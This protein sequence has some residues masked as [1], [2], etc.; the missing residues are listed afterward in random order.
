M[1]ADERETKKHVMRGLLLSG[2]LGFSAAL[3]AQTGFPD[4]QR[5]D[6]FMRDSGWGFDNHFNRCVWVY[7]GKYNA[8]KKADT[9]RIIKLCG[10]MIGNCYA[11]LT[12]HNWDGSGWRVEARGSGRPRNIP[13]GWTADADYLVL[14]VRRKEY[15][16]RRVR[17]DAWSAM[18]FRRE[19][20]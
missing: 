15:R 1:G 14:R 2:F 7:C 20:N 4:F 16:L 5:V 18:Y 19:S 10:G 6:S 9:I 13:A 12:L 11:N 17:S 3:Q 8:F